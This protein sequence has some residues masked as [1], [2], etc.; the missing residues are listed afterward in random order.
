M[1]RLFFDEPLPEELCE[2][3]ADINRS[4][5]ATPDWRT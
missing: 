2:A 4:H 5:V 3:L 1:A